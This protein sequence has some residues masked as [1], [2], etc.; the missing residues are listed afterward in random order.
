MHK[1]IFFIMTVIL[2]TKDIT[3]SSSES[4]T[5]ATSEMTPVVGQIINSNQII[6]STIRRVSSIL[7]STQHK[8][9][10]LNSI[11]RILTKP[12]SGTIQSLVMPNRKTLYISETGKETIEETV[13]FEYPNPFSIDSENER[14]TSIW[15]TRENNNPQVQEINILLINLVKNINDFSSIN[16]ILHCLSTGVLHWNS[17]GLIAQTFK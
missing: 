15:Q 7:I 6:N 16:S 2:I 10:I 9:C 8:E 13:I 14:L 3:T 12:N 17:D 1:K 11:T 4:K 5:T